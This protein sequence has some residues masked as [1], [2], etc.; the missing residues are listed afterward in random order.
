MAVELAG[1]ADPGS[2][3]R[4]MVVSTARDVF[5][6][7]GY[8]RTTMGDI[9][10]AAGLTRP[11]LYLSFRDKESIFHAVIRA[12]VADRIGEIRV[13]VAEREALQDKLAFACE[14]W[15][16]GAYEL[17]RDYPDAQ[18]LFDL[19][20][21]PVR[22]SYDAFEGLIAEIIRQP[23]ADSDLEISE[24]ALAAMISS[25]IKGFKD[26]ATDNAALCDL[27][28]ALAVVTAAGLRKPLV[29]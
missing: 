24:A 20:V 10:K 28:R 7:Y 21:L 15:V 17:V 22:E 16:L 29:E 23:L 3:R 4:T 11:T 9:A 6:R 5:L 25:A 8:G 13:G 1:E 2:D 12:M 26:M 18:D 19:K 27:V 14:T